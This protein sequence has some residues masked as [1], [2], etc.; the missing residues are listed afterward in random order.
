[1]D[2]IAEIPSKSLSEATGEIRQKLYEDQ[3]NEK[4]KTWVDEIK[5]EAHI[6]I[7]Y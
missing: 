6:K 3:V 7:M 4:F 5:K 1:V 2:E